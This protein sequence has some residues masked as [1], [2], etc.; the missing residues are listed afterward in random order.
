VSTALTRS[1]AS[2]ASLLL[3]GDGVATALTLPVH[4]LVLAVPA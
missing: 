1:T 4:A 3:M 2:R